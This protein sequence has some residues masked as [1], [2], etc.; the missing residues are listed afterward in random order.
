MGRLILRVA[1]ICYFT[2]YDRLS[3][4]EALKEQIEKV[5]T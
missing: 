2:A 5:A 4:E 3:E 1:F